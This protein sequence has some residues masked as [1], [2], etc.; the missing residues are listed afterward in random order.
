M[1]PF[2]NGRGIGQDYLISHQLT[3][4]YNV[5]IVSPLPSLATHLDTIG[6][7]IDETNMNQIIEEQQLQEVE[8]EKQGQQSQI[9]RRKKI[10]IYPVKQT[11]Y[12]SLY[13]DWIEIS[14]NLLNYIKSS[15]HP[16][17]YTMLEGV[18]IIIK[19]D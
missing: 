17:I 10:I 7:Y 2:P 14:F 19:Q 12:M 8:E 16:N 18:D 9:N 5:S 15:I 13:S 3:T 6:R 11:K 4:L 1:L